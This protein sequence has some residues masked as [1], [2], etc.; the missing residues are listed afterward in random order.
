MAI[1]IAEFLDRV[2]ESASE[3]YGMVCTDIIVY[4]GINRIVYIPDVTHHNTNMNPMGDFR[5]HL[6]HAL[7]WSQHVEINCSSEILGNALVSAGYQGILYEKTKDY[8]IYK[9]QKP[10]LST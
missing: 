3:L 1:S 2:T 8:A 5:T 9:L 10:A 7:L 6:G 4:D